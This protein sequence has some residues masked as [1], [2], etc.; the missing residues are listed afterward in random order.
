M[1]ITGDDGQMQGIPLIVFVLI[2]GCVTFS[3]YFKF[4]NL[5]MFGHAINV[6][7]GKYDKPDDDG[8]ISSFQAL[9]SALSATVGLG[10]IAG[11]AV[12][13]TLGGPGAI[14]WMW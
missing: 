6:V 9:A 5:R 13:M 1:F 8:E 14:F 3:L 4:I 11:V 2:I 12:A 7:R 10:N